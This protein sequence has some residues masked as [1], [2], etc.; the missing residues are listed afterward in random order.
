LT[1]AYLGNARFRWLSGQEI[2]LA[3]IPLR[4]LRVNYVGELGWELHAPMAD[5]ARLYDAIRAAGTAHGIADF[6][7]AAVNSLR[8]EKAYCG[9]G[10]ELT[11]E[12]TLIEAAST[13]FYAPDK[14]EFR[15]RAATEA[16]RAKGI[17]TGLVYGE[18]SATDCDIYG[19]EAVMQGGR[20]VGVC[21][22]GGYGHA[23][24]KSLA[25][26]YVAPD[27]RVGLEVVILGERHAFTPLDA[28]AWDP[29]NARQ[30]A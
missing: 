9:M 13:R 18:V 7:G 22:S 28:P 25:F 30:K 27:A 16:V 5:L 6:G 14:G 10:S 11:N 2:T 20:V 12:I 15:G 21:T 23:T 3:G 4:A 17:A 29:S 24:G 1:D 8:M 26:A 19:G